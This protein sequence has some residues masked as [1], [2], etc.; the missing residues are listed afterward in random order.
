MDA[1]VGTNDLVV[2]V[3]REVAVVAV[4]A[5]LTSHRDVVPCEAHVEAV[6]QVHPAGVQVHRVHRKVINGRIARQITRDAVHRKL[7][8]QV[9][10]HVIGRIKLHVVPIARKWR[11]RKGRETDVV[12]LGALGNQVAV[13]RHAHAFCKAHCYAFFNR[14]RLA[15]WHHNVARHVVHEA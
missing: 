12:I 10:D 11:R 8:V 3:L 2:Q 15:F 14:Q 5:I 13:A 6:G 7:V 1:V 4:D 9:T